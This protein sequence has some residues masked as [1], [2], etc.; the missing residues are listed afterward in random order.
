VIPDLDRWLADP[1]IRLRHQRDAR[2]APERLWEEAQA[3]TIA[4]SH[5][6][7]RVVRWRLPGVPGNATYRELFSSHPFT[8][9]EE[10]E[11]HSISGICGRIWNRKREFARLEDPEAFARCEIPGTARVVFAHWVHPRDDGRATLAS[12]VRVEPADRQARLGLRLVRPLIVAF[13]HLIAS[14]ALA[15]ATRRAERG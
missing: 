5:L 14:E 13:E 10:G 4:D 11:T 1:A 2:A 9:L 15:V 6:L 7:G 8:V 3:V 12:E